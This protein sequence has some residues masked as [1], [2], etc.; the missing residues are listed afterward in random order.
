MR[1][2]PKVLE[3]KAGV[4][5]GTMIR[6]KA[7]RLLFCAVLI[8]L[9]CVAHAEPVIKIVALKSRT[10]DEVIPVLQPLVPPTGVVTGLADQLVIRTT[11][12]NLRQVL[13]V[14]E[15]LDKPPQQLVVRVREGRMVNSRSRGAGVTVEGGKRDTQTQITAD[16]R[17]STQSGTG[18]FSV[19]VLEGREAFIRTGRSQPVQERSSIS[20]GDQTTVSST[21]RYV[22]ADNGFYVRPRLI[23]G[24][25]TLDIAP[26]RESFRLDGSIESR[27]LMSTVSAKLGEWVAIGGAAHTATS[28]G[29]TR[30]G[31]RTWTS[32]MSA[33]FYL[34]VDIVR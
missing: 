8:A 19:L 21:T 10:V 28:A 13:A 25:V 14:L 17:Y 22:H 31:V 24:G 29:S 4:V 7:L 11:T 16:R 32:R 1:L 20:T 18:D 9:S 26:Q 33:T 27:S 34:K 23:E 2:W 12:D 6:Q 3:P 5:G 30:G 15:S